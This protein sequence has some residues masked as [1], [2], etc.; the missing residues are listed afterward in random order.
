MSVSLRDADFTLRGSPLANEWGL[1]PEVVQQIWNRF[2]RVDVDLFSSQ[3]N[4]HCPLWFSSRRIHPWGWMRLH[5]RLGREAALH[6]YSS[7]SHSPSVGKSE[8]RAAVS[9]PD[10]P[11]LP[12]SAV[13]SRDDPDVGSPALAHPS[14]L[15]G[16]VAGGRLDRCAAHIGPISRDLAPERDRLTDRW[17]RP[18]RRREQD[19]P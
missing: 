9:H 18:S 16:S 3:N 19:P 17:F 1:H 10:S 13:V 12:F 2:R 4:T 7:L 14:S 8:T 5:V 15:G 11:G 6:L